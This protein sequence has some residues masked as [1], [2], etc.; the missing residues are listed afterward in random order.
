[1]FIENMLTK[2]MLTEN[3]FT[4]NINTI[5]QQTNHIANFLSDEKDKLKLATEACAEKSIGLL[6]DNIQDNSL[7]LLFEWNPAKSTLTVV[8]TDDTKQHDAP[9]SVTGIFAGLSDSELIQFWL[10]D[11][12]TTSTTF[13]KFSLVAIFHS[14][15]RS[16][17]QLL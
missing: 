9:H 17:T 5:T 7:Y 3:I 8:L 14:S 16:N 12:L 4:E 13:L 10:Y 1:M 11:Y 6:A 2:N 15:T